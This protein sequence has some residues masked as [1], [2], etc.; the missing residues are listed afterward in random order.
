MGEVTVFVG[1]LYFVWNFIFICS[2]MFVGFLIGRYRKLILRF[3]IRVETLLKCL[4]LFYLFFVDKKKFT[5]IQYYL[6]TAYDNPLLK[7]LIYFKF[8]EN[9]ICWSKTVLL[10]Y[11]KC[12]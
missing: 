10:Y 4:I 5:I 7:K 3:C 6:F 2:A 11:V 12:F 1:F 9:K 8:G